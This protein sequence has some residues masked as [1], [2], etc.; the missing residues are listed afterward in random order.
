[1]FATGVT[2]VALAVWCIKLL[3][4]GKQDEI[5]RL[6]VERD[7]FQKLIIEDWQSSS[8]ANPPKVIK[9]K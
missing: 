6:V 8:V 3:V 4:K 2:T 1:V 9:K 7:R 5:D